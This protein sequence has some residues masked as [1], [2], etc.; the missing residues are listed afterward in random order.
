MS[1]HDVKEIRSA[2]DVIDLI[3][4]FFNPEEHQVF[5]PVNAITSI[6]RVSPNI[7]KM[8]EKVVER[9]VMLDDDYL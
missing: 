3:K 1:L 4:E 7:E 2:D 5:E 6:I 8:E 9:F